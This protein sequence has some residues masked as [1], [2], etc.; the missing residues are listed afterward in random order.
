MKKTAIAGLTCMLI[1]A[2]IFIA[3]CKK[4]A[5][6]STQTAQSVEQKPVVLNLW[7]H[8]DPNRQK[9]EEQF[10]KEYMAANPHITI[11][12]SV[13]P[14]TKIQDLIPTAYA[15][16]Q[17]PSIWNLELQKAYPIFMQG[18][19]APIPPEALGF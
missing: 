8:E 7:T 2:G 3:G 14:S 9:M 19:C 6:Q 15:A 4:E 12:Y 10:A 18:L 5:A 1:F 13:Y 11:N 17:G 16:K